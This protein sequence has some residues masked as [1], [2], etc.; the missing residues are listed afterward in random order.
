MKYFKNIWAVLFDFD[1][2]IAHTLPIYRR[3]MMAFFGARDLNI[4]EEDFD[5]DGYFMKS[6]DQI[7]S[8]LQTKYS[9]SI[10]LD[11]LKEEV[12]CLQTELME[13]W[14]EQDPSLRVLLDYFQA[15]DIRCAIGSN[16][17]VWRI[18]ELLELCNMASYFHYDWHDTVVG[19]D[20]LRHHKPHPEVWEKAAEK[21]C[22]PIA[23]CLVIE[24][25]YLG[26]EWAKSLGIP[27]AYYHRFA[28]RE[29][30]ICSEI[31]TLS[32]RDFSEIVYLMENIESSEFL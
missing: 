8:L 24:D 19:I 16:S 1:G 3:A 13:V 31:A 18:H 27:S 23:N 21:V 20:Q 17:H 14:F 22:T 30:Q 6:L 5:K 32:I 11:A 12:N 25:G 29:N 28:D 9:Y 10:S 26:L 4:S 15:R 2:V 7:V